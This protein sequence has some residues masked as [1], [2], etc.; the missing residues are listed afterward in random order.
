MVFLGIIV[1]LE[2]VNTAVHAPPTYPV[3]CMRFSTGYPLH[4]FRQELPCFHTTVYAFLPVTIDKPVVLR[5]TLETAGYSNGD[6]LVGS[7]NGMDHTS[8]R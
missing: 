6:S 3:A 4:K 7:I 5:R 2:P 8:G 1:R